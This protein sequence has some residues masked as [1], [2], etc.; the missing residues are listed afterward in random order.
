[1]RSPAL[2]KLLSNHGR[3][4]PDDPEYRRVYLL[5]VVLLL[6]IA[7]T[8]CFGILNAFALTF[9]I[10]LWVA[11]G[12]L[13]V[14][15]LL[16]FHRTDRIEICSYI[17]VAIIFC[18]LAATFTLIGNQ[19]Y[20]LSWVCVFPPLAIF[21]LGRMKGS[22]ASLLLL[23]YL[24]V[25]FVLGHQ[26]WSPAAFT[27]KSAVNI[28]G[29]VISLVLLI[30]YFELSRSEAA[31]AVRQKNA[32]LEKANS[33]LGTSREELRLILDSTA[34]AIFGVDMESRCTFCNAS[35]VEML[36]LESQADLLGKDIHALIHNRRRDGSTLPRSECNIVRTC[37]EGI[38][39]HA[40]DEVFWRPGGTSFD[41]E[42]NSYPQYKDGEIVGAVVTFN[43]N[44]LKKLHEEQIEYFSSHDS[45]TGL[46]N[47][48]RFEAILRKMDNRSGLPIS[49]IMGDLNG[50]KLMNDVF[51]H[52]AGDELLVKAAEVL[53]KVCRTD[54]AIARI[55]GDEFVIMLPRTH[56]S[57]ARLVM[58]RIR[59]S[60]AREQVNSIMCSISLGCDTKTVAEKSLDTVMQNAE[61]EMYRVKSMMRSKVNDDMINAII[62]MLYERNTWEEQH[63]EN[64]SALCERIG[65]ALGMGPTELAQ[66]RS[67]GFLHD[68]GMVGIDPRI[69]DKK[70]PFS[71]EEARE[72]EQHPIIGF[73]ILNLFDHT[74]GLAENVYSH[75][76]RWDGKGFPRALRGNEIP[77][78]ARII[79][80]AGWYDTILRGLHSQ[81]LPQKEAV[82]RLK[83]DAG[84]RLDPHIVDVFVRL[85]ES[86]EVT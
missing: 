3:F 84:T 7:M 11:T 73:R 47:R 80:V 56:N 6:Y 58:D 21:L 42:Y 41:V 61:N 63:S 16:Y 14:L 45:L 12:V 34:E 65:T 23:C 79:A 5:N 30:I 31:S 68:I 67:S 53:R 1:M 62:M 28:M 35:C 66:L 44:T 55:G 32:E 25:L 50:L 71:E 83:A 24:T 39:V 13:C 49:V 86:E 82:A 59:D 4:K 46:L 57:D 27:V 15:T 20:I 51:G 81:P 43:D 54:D 60:L 75:H 52:C 37:M 17:V 26:G 74:L 2:R 40:D 64:V 18:M 22:I 9:G 33:A 19:S 8:V 10:Y 78:M 72:Y 69:V 76:E 48:S 36:G 70:V 29:S 38:P 85:I 77:L